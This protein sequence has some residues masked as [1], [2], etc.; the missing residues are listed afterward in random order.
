MKII[1]FSQD[2][3]VHDRRFLTKLAQSSHEIWYLRL[4]TS[5][6]PMET[7][8]IPSGIKIVDWMGNRT[9][10]LQGLNKLKLFLDFRRIVRQLQPDLIHAGPVQ[11]CG[12]FVALTGFKP[13][14]LMSWGSDILFTPGKN[15]INL[16]ITKFTINRASMILCDCA[17]VQNGIRE[18][19]D[20][21]QDRIIILPWGV[22]LNKFRPAPSRIKLR[23]KLNWQNNKV[24]IST[25]SF[26]PLYGI[27]ILLQTAS[28][29]IGKKPDV[30]FIVVG[31]GSLRPQV[32]D[33]IAKHHLKHIV[34]L[35]GRVPH[36]LLPD[37]FN[38]ADLYVSSSY[39][40]GTSASLLEAMACGL[41]VVV[42]DF[43]SNREWISPGI[44][45]CLA[46]IGDAQ[47]FSS[48]I[49]EVLER[50]NNARDMKEANLLTVQQKA[51]WNKNS[52]L[53]IETYEGLLGNPS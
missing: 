28:I 10:R 51:D 43:P 19:A 27:E 52:N 21:P 41:P 23:E 42:S 44:N 45:G 11:T 14:L 31:D 20:Y 24:V 3:T 35:T 48:A 53:L 13:F 15:M 30:R 32:E 12:F 46:S 36:D 49:I 25:R 9:Y 40:D 8:P 38:E 22:D 16:L 6:T 18:L 4:E 47:A 39:S 33:F 5:P 17:A 26:E 50:E 7:L 1:Y 37:Y 34:Y 29:V 2:Y